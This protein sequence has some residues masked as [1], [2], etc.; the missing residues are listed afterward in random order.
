MSRSCI[1]IHTFE[2]CHASA[3]VNSPNRERMTAASAATAAPF[4]FFARARARRAVSAAILCR[5]YRKDRVTRRAIMLFFVA[6]DG[7]WLRSVRK[8]VMSLVVE[9]CDVEGSLRSLV[10]R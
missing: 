5:A 3:A 2:L 7:E 10:D 1:C 6:D 9:E 4:S 8:E